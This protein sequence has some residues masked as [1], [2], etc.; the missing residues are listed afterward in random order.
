MFDRSPLSG[1]LALALVLLLIFQVVP[2]RAHT[3]PP[4]DSWE[5]AAMR[6]EQ[7]ARQEKVDAASRDLFYAISQSDYS[8][9]ALAIALGADVNQCVA[10]S[11]TSRR[12]CAS[13][14][15]DYAVQ[16]YSPHE[17]EDGGQ[18][19][20]SV[21]RLLLR[22]GALLVDDDITRL[23]RNPLSVRKLF[24]KETL[25]LL[26]LES[27]YTVTPDLLA[28]A[29]LYRSGGASYR[30]SYPL[31]MLLKTSSYTVNSTFAAREFGP[32]VTREI[33]SHLQGLAN[34]GRPLQSV[35]GLKDI[36]LLHLAAVTGNTEVASFLIRSGADIGARTSTGV[37]AMEIAYALWMYTWNDNV[38]GRE[39]KFERP[40][41]LDFLRLMLLHGQSPQEIVRDYANRPSV[42]E[43]I[44]VHYCQEYTLTKKSKTK[45]GLTLE[46][47]FG[48]HFSDMSWQL[49]KFDVLNT[50]ASHLCTIV[51]EFSGVLNADRSRVRIPL[52]Y[53]DNMFY[54]AGSQ[55]KDLRYSMY[56]NGRRVTPPAAQRFWESLGLS[57]EEPD[58][59]DK[60][61]MLD[62]GDG[63]L[64]SFDTRSD[65]LRMKTPVRP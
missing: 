13:R 64:D 42:Y 37:T 61:N 15:L 38:W 12:S 29:A 25:L 27:G 63:L 54:I 46:E 5:E 3:T 7:E 20:L 50:D 14:M 59:M 58:E 51:V 49:K 11:D 47:F 1:G 33:V 60:L 41:F 21:V 39:Y 40:A 26:F 10:Y 55:M 34:L 44:F 48:Q 9:A 43:D 30:S 45:A 8:K 28:W 32:R 24:P 65:G 31:Q 18:A 16:L 4:P 22:K 23:R 6:L 62:S 56:R 2:A 53:L 57:V 36:T 35:T 52:A 17:E 19:S